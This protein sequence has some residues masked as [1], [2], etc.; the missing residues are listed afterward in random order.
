MDIGL[1]DITVVRSQRED[2]ELPDNMYPEEFEHFYGYLN[3]MELCYWSRLGQGELAKL[4]EARLLVPDRKD[5]RYRPKLVLWAEKLKYLLDEGWTIPEI[6]SW[7]RGRFTTGE[8][9]V[10]PPVRE[11]WQP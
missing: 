10:W 2:N 3:Q 5:G 8:P 7:A 1:K 6:K 4:H 9:N 11:Q